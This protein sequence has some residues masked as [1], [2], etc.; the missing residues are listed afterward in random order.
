MSQSIIATLILILLEM[1]VKTQ[2]NLDL[3]VLVYQVLGKH[4]VQICMFLVTGFQFPPKLQETWVLLVGNYRHRIKCR[5]ASRHL[6]SQLSNQ[7]SSFFRAEPHLQMLK[8]VADI[9]MPS[10]PPSASLAS[11]GDQKETKHYDQVNTV[12]Q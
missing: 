9:K 5:P 6:Q 7:H 11:S 8:M 1:I 3:M 12:T 10:Q 2:K 4:V